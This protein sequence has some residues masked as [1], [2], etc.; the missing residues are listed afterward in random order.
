NKAAIRSLS[1]MEIKRALV[2]FGLD[3]QSIESFEQVRKVIDAAFLV[4]CGDFMGFS[5]TFPRHNVLRWEFADKAC[6]AYRGMQRMGVVDRYECGVLY[7]VCCW[8]DHVGVRYAASRDITGCL[9]D[10]TG[11]CSGELRFQF[12]EPGA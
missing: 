7:R 8:L 6:F 1:A 11:T 12:A 10:E 2:L 3:A 9:M 5:Y 4:S